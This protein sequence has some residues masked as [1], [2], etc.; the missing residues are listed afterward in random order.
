M[1]ASKKLLQGQASKTVGL[2]DETEHLQQ[3]K[4]ALH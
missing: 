3:N 4:C 1:Q 2:S